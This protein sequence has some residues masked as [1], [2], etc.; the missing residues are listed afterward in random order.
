MRKTNTVLYFVKYPLPGQVKTR[1]A[2]TIGPQEAARVYQ[3]LAE[4]NYKVLSLAKDTDIVIMF[5]PPRNEKEIKQW[6]SGANSYVAQKGEDLGERLS[7]AFQ[8]AFD[9]GYQAVTVVGSDI[10]ELTPTIVEQ[11]FVA[12]TR[13]DVVIGPAK[14]GG[15]YLIGLSS[16]QPKLFEGINW[17]TSVVLSQTYR[18][19][20]T[21]RL[22][23]STLCPLED[24]D[25]IK[26]GETHEFIDTQSE[27]RTG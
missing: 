17:S 20:G 6:L 3:E 27:K 16:H 9:H 21:L 10:L 19:I 1:L 24:L 2:R 7:H 25:D 5:D 4:N 22:K 12:L 13:S 26:R 14:D 15:Y 23:F 8:W 11:S 18:I